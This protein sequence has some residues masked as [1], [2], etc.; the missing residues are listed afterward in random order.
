MKKSGL[1]VNA[2]ARRL[3]IRKATVIDWLGR[4]SYEER[5]GWK[6]GRRTYTPDEEERVA[7]LKRE[8]IDGKKYFLGAP[9]VRMDYAKRFPGDP[10][11]SLWFVNDVVRRRGLQTHEPK[12]RSRGQ[13]I[14][15]RL[16]FPVRSIVGLGRIQQASDFIGKKY[17][18]GRKEPVSIFSTGYYQWLNLYQVWRVSSE[19]AENAITCLAGLW[20]RFPIP[21]VMRMDNGMTFRGTGSA[22]A[23][24]GRCV[25]FLLNRRV[26]PLFS[27]PYQSYTNPHIEGHNRTF[28]EK[29]WSAERFTSDRQI[30]EACVRFNAE[31]EE[32]CRWSFKDR[33]NGHALRFLSETPEVDPREVLRSAKGKKICFIRFVER[34]KEKSDECCVV[35]LNRFVRIPDPYLNQYVLVT[36]DLETASVIVISEH[37]GRT[38]RVL[39]RQFPYTL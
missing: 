21:N 6:Q 26:T 18:A 31:S 7:L 8:R 19:K 11:P 13:D 34:W 22:E 37:D 29:L 16:K 36:L 10:L 30:D 27:S 23:H 35:I 5:R 12:K 4:G 39:K 2:I 20:K 25:V 32:F 1:G 3:G 15:S 14:V 38:T 24:V 28:T 33:L 17:V 9:H